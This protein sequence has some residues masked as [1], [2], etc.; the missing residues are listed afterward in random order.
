MVKG[1]TGWERVV[2]TSARR[3]VAMVLAALFLAAAGP[4]L[5]DARLEN[6]VVTPAVQVNQEVTPGRNHFG[7]QILVSPKD[8][9]TLVIVESEQSTSSGACPV[10]VSRD[11]GR[12]WSTRRAMPRPEEFGT[13]TRGSFGPSLDARFGADGTLYVLAAGA[14]VA[15]GLGVTDPYVARSTD[16]G[17]T[18]QF[19]VLERGAN[20]VEFSKP[21]GT[22]VMD[23]GRYNRL[24]LATHPT[25][26][27]RV[28]AGLL[29]NPGTLPILTEANIRTLVSVSTDGGRTFGPLVNIYGE[30]PVDQIYGGDVPSVAVDKD[31]TIYAFTKER[32]PSP[33]TPPPA[34]PPAAA[35]D[36]P[37]ATVAATT[38]TQPPGA[39]CPAA[40]ARVAPLSPPTTVPAPNP[41]PRLGAV[42]AGERLLFAKSTDEGK[43]WEARSIDDSTAICRFCLTTPE[44]AVD[45]KTGAIY[46]VFEHSDSGPPTARDD[47]NIFF[48]ASNDGGRTFSKRLQLN[49]DVAPGRTPNYN[50]LFPGIGVAP[51]GRVDVAWYDFRTDALYHPE[52][53]GFSSLLGEVCWDVQYTYSND[54]GRTWARQNLRVSDRSMNRDEGFSVNPKYAPRG[55][56]GVAA[57]DAAAYIVWPDSRAGNPLVP[58]QDTYVATVIHEIETNDDGGVE[59]SSLALGAVIGIVLSGLLV[60]GGLLRFR[61]RA[62][63]PDA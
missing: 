8:R 52:G 18:W 35:P 6:P 31:G 56:M 1:R 28:Y 38:T 42:G 63:A 50:Q 40:P 21:D 44:A 32:P 3:L 47:R 29:V 61:S 19:T 41:A 2:G 15:T 34:A 46:V 4:V 37:P 48:M 39:G 12:T 27:K 7:Q 33:P 11:A 58:V 9:R 20:E 60:L 25:D 62:A 49:D 24:R 30:V 13:C 26:P 55:P 57:T 5:A 23:T 22:K 59:G 36:T 10:H 53:R 14:G 17:E 43:T 16:L 54:G 51:N 45:A